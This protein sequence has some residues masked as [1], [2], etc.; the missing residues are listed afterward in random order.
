MLE[1]VDVDVRV[2]H[3]HRDCLPAAKLH[4]RAKVAVLGV[5]P[6]CPGVPAIMRREIRDACPLASARKRLLETAPRRCVVDAFGPLIWK[7]V[8]ATKYFAFAT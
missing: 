2:P 5:M 4:E 1:F 3:D 6:S 7:A 8:W